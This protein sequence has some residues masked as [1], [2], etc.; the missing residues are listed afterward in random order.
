M[1]PKWATPDRQAQL[2]SLFLHSNGFCVF[3]HKPCLIPD[4]HYE[5]FIEYLIADWQADDKAQKQ[6]EWQA[7][8][9]R[10]HS[11]GERSYPLRGQFSTIGKDIFYADQPQ[12][13]FVGLSISGLTFKPFAKIRLASSFVSLHIDLGNTL[14]SV[15]KS[16]RRKAIRYGKA[17]PV[18]AQSQIDRICSLAV[19]HYLENR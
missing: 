3:G 13:Y 14:K 1:T 4:H 7:E 8:R 15:S 16:K 11:L 10:I 2:V 17:L 9:R 12:F 5:V 6:G 19:R 18:E